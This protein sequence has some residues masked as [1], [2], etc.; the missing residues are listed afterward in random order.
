MSVVMPPA[1]AECLLDF[2]DRCRQIVGPDNVREDIDALREFD[3][4][5]GDR[6]PHRPVLVVAPGSI[7]E[8]SRIMASANEAG[9]DVAPRGAGMSY[10]AGYV[11]ATPATMMLDMRRMNR[12]L[13]VSA[14][15]MTVTVEAGC[16]WADLL[17]TLTPL[18]LRTPFFGPMS[19]ISS[20]VGGGLS[21]L[22]AML[23][24]GQHGTSSESVVALT[25][26][27]ADGRLIRTGARGPNGQ[28]PFYRHFGPDLAGLF[29]GDCGALGVKAEITLRLMRKPAV[30]GHVSFAFPTGESLMRA[31]GE[32]ARQGLAAEM[33]AFDPGLTRVRM[34]RESMA[35]DL[36]KAVAVAGQQR[37]LLKGLVEVGRMALAGR[38]FID[39]EAF[40]LH[41]NAEG[42]CAEAV[43]FDLEAA[44]RVAAQEGGREIPNTIAKV[45]RAVPFPPA[46]SILGPDGER[47]LP[48]HGQVPL[49]A[50]PDVL[51]ALTAIFADMAGA[52]KRHGMQ[53]GFLF[54]SM[55]TN[56]I[57]LEPVLYW[58]DE[59]LPVHEAHIEP[60]HLSRLPVLSA[61][62]EAHAVA[63][64][65]KARIIEVFRQ[66]GAGHFQIG[67]TYP[68]RESR[69]PDSWALLAAIKQHV[70]PH[71]RLNPGVLGFDLP[72][73]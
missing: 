14:Q 56:A 52:F 3:H 16:T 11:P 4:D 48:I 60:A 19:G 22:N 59:R 13:S 55:S 57:I 24:A 28:S 68:Y 25:V 47:W 65:A 9:V 41:L 45:I 54:T 6:G 8:L 69:D 63:L 50:A 66:Q 32:I 1:S 70:D 7:G 12:V 34:R 21:Q 46:N 44:R 23:G 2:A 35:S 73:H 20:T 53:H 15:D 58:P 30:E 18:G 64:Q 43:E 51:A 42:R 26:V 33:C 38:D 40:S 71:G 29:C 17:A 27:L 37:S 67:R 49:S 39:V 62:H 61:N 31:M 36:K 10:T 72:S 5:I